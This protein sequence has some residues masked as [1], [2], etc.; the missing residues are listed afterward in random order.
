MGSQYIYKKLDALPS[1]AAYLGSIIRPDYLWWQ[2]SFE[3]PKV[4]TIFPLKS[5]STSP[6][7]AK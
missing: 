1:E 6:D 2:A 4:F 7:A 3:D 5:P